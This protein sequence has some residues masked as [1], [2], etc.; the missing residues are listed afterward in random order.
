METKLAYGIEELA[1]AGPLGRSYI[2]LA[3]K[4]GRLIAQKAGSRTIV[5]HEN[6]QAFIHSLPV[7]ESKAM[8][9]RAA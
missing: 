9:D 3:I 8:P 2:F 5:T 4:E 1:K 6:W 7:V